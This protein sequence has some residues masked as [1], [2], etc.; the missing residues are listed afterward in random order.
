MK[1]LPV[2]EDG[3]FL[4]FN[5]QR[6]P[7]SHMTIYKTRR[8]NS[9]YNVHALWFFLEHKDKT[10]AD[11]HR[12]CMNK[13]IEAVSIRDKKELLAYLTGVSDR[14]SRIATGDIALEPPT[15]KQR[16][17]ET[18]LEQI[19]QTEEQKER[20]PLKR[21]ASNELNSPGLQAVGATM[22][23]RETKL[24]DRTTILHADKIVSSLTLTYA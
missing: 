9:C 14:S 10:Q 22:V 2:L 7:K 11:Y 15:K 12:L 4:V 6:V 3:G 5:K 16:R 20:R 24:R 13:S 8:E 18:G 19:K 1:K 21:K 17:D 23:S